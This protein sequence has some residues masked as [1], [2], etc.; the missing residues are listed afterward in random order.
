MLFGNGK[1]RLG[2]VIDKW[3]GNTRFVESTCAGGDVVGQ[4]NLFCKMIVCHGCRH[5][6]RHRIRNFDLRCTIYFSHCTAEESRI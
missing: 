2:D 4:F 5:R 6:M 1:D 3:G